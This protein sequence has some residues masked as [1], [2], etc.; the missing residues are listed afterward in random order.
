MRPVVLSIAGLDPGGGAGVLADVRTFEAHDCWAAAVVATQT[1]QR[2]GSVRDVRATPADL[3]AGQIRAV[4]DDHAVS[5]VK[6]GLLA[7]AE[8]IDAVV[9]ALGDCAAPVVLDPVLDSTSGTRFVDDAALAA[10]RERLLP[11]VRVVTPNLPEALR[12][13]GCAVTSAATD[14][15]ARLRGCGARHVLITGGEA[16]GAWCDDQLFDDSGTYRIRHRAIET[17]RVHGTGCAHS[18]SLAA[19]LAHGCSVREAAEGAARWVEGALTRGLAFG[20][21]GSP[22][23]AWP[24]SRRDIAASTERRS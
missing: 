24:A 11:R 1:V 21:G 9:S 10:L 4:L 15:A 8:T 17:D 2:V 12:L 13:A 7:A 16:D 19:R 22:D 3:V 14:A 5:A 20:G 18:S 6:I 23:T